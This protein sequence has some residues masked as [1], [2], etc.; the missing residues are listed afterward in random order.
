M[1]KKVLLVMMA[2]IMSITLVGCS[3]EDTKDTQNK[4]YVKCCR[5]HSSC[6]ICKERSE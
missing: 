3:K 2:T 5:A 1:K 6:G 4:E